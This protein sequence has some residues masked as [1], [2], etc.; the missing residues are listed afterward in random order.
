M[1][2]LE[3]IAADRGAEARAIDG[4]PW[5]P[6][7]S[8]YMRFD[9]GGPVHP[10]QAFYGTDSALRLTPV[11]ACARL[12]ADSVASLPVKVYSNAGG[13]PQRYRGPTIFDQPSATG[14][15]YD[16]L[17]QMMTSLVL[18]GNAWGFVTGRDG[19]GYPTGIEWMPPER[20]SV[21]DDE[22]Q[23]W[24]PLRTRIYFYGRLMRRDEVFHIRAF[25]LPGRTEGISP[26]KAFALTITA[27][28]EQARYGADWYAAG[29]FPPGTFKNSEIEIDAEQAAEIRA[30]LTASIRRRQPLV[31]GRDWDYHPVT[32]PPSEAQ[33]VEAMQLT[34]N[35]IASVYGLP[36]DR[37][38]GKR[39]DS[40][41]Y[42]T[43][44]DNTLQVIEALRPWLVRAEHAFF[45]IL[46]QNRYVRFDTDALL[47]TDIKTRH[48][49]YQID[50]DIGLR[51]TDEIRATEDWEPLENGAGKEPI[52]LQLLIGM[53]RETK[54]IPKSYSKFLEP[55]PIA[56]MPEPVPAGSPAAV[57]PPETLPGANGQAQPGGL[58]GKIAAARHRIT[59][60][61]YTGWLEEPQPLA[62]VNGHSRD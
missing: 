45:T 14:T 58:L 24:N 56:P 55:A 15:T 33:A 31:Y 25:S 34:A 30:S 60:P 40:L 1:G 3:R 17:H 39:G 42:A 13:M 19:Y 28:L 20:V 47:K 43:V 12:L 27:G 7:D 38:G 5:R 18:Q 32:V 54:Q 52:S 50:R 62:H 35:Q 2:L 23:P 57:N 53:S 9:A 4:V 49:I 11:Y 46:P 41:T 48:E 6:W 44:Q 61:E 8:P 16:W 21:I 59:E 26:L 10:T 51:T 22:T 37:A 29:G 36:A